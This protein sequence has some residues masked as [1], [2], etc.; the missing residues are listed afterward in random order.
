MP[1]LNDFH[2]F[3]S[4]SGGLSSGGCGG[5]GCGGIIFLLGIVGLIIKLFS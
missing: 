3:N 1:D 5:L 2:A 4:T